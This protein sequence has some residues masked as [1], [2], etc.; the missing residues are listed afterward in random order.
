[1]ATSTSSSRDDRPAERYSL[2]GSSFVRKESSPLRAVRKPQVSETRVQS[3]IAS[4]RPK[5]S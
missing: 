5:N 2:T 4:K 1:M 3:A